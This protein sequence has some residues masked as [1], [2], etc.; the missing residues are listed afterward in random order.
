MTVDWLLFGLRLLAPILLYSFLGLIIRRMVRLPHRSRSSRDY[1]RRLDAPDTTFVLDL[2]NTVGREAGNSL[3]ID[4]HFISARHAVLTY[5]DG[6]WWLADLDSTNGTL[7][8]EVPV[9]KATPLAYGDVVSLG[10]VQLRLE[11]GG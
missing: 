2:R 1:L 11:K 10:E 7:V 5:E 3:I 9:E 4:D 6:I 8:N